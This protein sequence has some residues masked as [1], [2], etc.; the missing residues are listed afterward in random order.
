MTREARM[1]DI[2]AEIERELNDRKRPKITLKD[3]EHAFTR[4]LL[5]GNMS[6]SMRAIRVPT[7]SYPSL[8]AELPHMLRFVNHRISGAHFIYKGVAVVPDDTISDVQVD[9]R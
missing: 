6:S 2:L 5:L 3:V 7:A 4:V 1:S 8:F 9:L